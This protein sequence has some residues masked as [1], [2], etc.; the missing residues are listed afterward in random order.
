MRWKE[1]KEAPLADFGVY[2]D[3]DKEGSFRAGDVR[4]MQSQKWVERV[5]NAF[6]KTEFDFNIYVYNAKDGVMRYDGKYIIPQEEYAKVHGLTSLNA[7]S[8]VLGFRPPNA[9]RSITVLLLENEGSERLPLTPWILAHRVAHALMYADRSPERYV[10]FDISRIIEDYDR[11]FANFISDVRIPM[12]MVRK[13]D[14]DN[15]D[16]AV[17]IANILGKFGSARHG[18]VR[19]G[20]EF[21]V[22]V[23]TQYLVKGAVTFNRV[24]IPG[25]P[26]L[27]KEEP[28]EM[29]LAARKFYQDNRYAGPD[30][31]A[32]AMLK[33]VRK[34]VVGGYTAFDAEGNPMAAF[35][36]GMEGEALQTRI[37]QYQDRGLTVKPN[38]HPTAQIKKYEEYQRKYKELFDAYDSWLEDTEVL[39]GPK[40]STTDYLDTVLDKWE[41]RLNTSIRRIIIRCIGKAL[42][43]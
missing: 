37:K 41:E 30:D 18:T 21:K 35:G 20:G 24:E 22:E 3:M 4:A 9:E 34:P 7:I 1:I 39:R 31:F 16:E 12:E 5:H 42:V 28:S 27:P 8:D 38:R 32:K 19:D 40:Q 26:R 17:K 15:E 43:L 13:T 33:P 14:W 36:A 2:G 23:F 6:K 29:L 25:V 11:E 10:S